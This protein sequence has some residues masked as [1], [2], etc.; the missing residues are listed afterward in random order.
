MRKVG[1][2]ISLL[3]LIQLIRL[4]LEKTITYETKKPVLNVAS[5]NEMYVNS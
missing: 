4:K 5:K 3:D 1:E 2:L